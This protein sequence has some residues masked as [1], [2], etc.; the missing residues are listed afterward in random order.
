MTNIFK[1]NKIALRLTGYFSIVLVI[2][3][4]FV[5]GVFAHLFQQHTIELHQNEMRIRAEHLA[6]MAGNAVKNQKDGKHVH[7]R[8]MMGNSSA[9]GYMGLLENED[10]GDAWIVDAN[11]SLLMP[12]RGRM[13]CYSYKDLPEEADRVVKEAFEGRAV[14]S[15]SF[16]TLLGV[17]T[18][19]VG[20]PIYDESEA[21]IGVVLLH[22]PVEGIAEATHA[23]LFI[24]LVSMLLALLLALLLAIGF[25]YSFTRPL[26]KMNRMAA[27][28]AAGDY[29]ARTEVENKD[30]IG[31]L[32][33]TLDVLSE[34]LH[35]ASLEQDKL[36]KLRRDFISNISHE[37]RTPVTVLKGSLEALCDKVVSEENEVE[38]YQ[39]EMLRE[40]IYLERLV[41]DLLELSRLQSS[42]FG[43]DVRAIDLCDVI[44][45][46]GRFGQK[47]AKKYDRSLCVSLDA[48]MWPMQGDYARLRQLLIILLDNALKFSYP[49]T[50]V[51]ISLQKG[52]LR[53]DNYGEPIAAAEIPYL[54]ERFHKSRDEKNKTG[55]GLGLPIARQI[56]ARHGWLLEVSS[57]PGGKTAFF[58][59]VK[60]TD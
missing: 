31:A 5:G 2:F 60:N 7:G 18:M 20:M 27:L 26:N 50:T 38:K 47:L 43:I 44:R 12:Q 33:R 14:F 25:S 17:P 58:L 37:L 6:V 10:F 52:I 53:V 55:T 11:L 30:E 57:E 3:A 39:Q 13:M 56:A 28:L 22:S 24:L 1:K 59:V 8:G 46:A 16:S 15:R 41:N 45:D 51:E 35:E 54:F 23:G 34:Q 9:M 32:A 29:T 36:E 19:T 48:E 40:S 21:V 42:D 4:L 49:E